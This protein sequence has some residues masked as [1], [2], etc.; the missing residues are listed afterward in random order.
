MKTPKAL[1][2]NHKK[3]TITVTR[4]LNPL[5]FHARML[6]QLIKENPE[7]TVVEKLNHEDS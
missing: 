2:L 6:N 5:S 1:Q 7:Y 4:K 3:K